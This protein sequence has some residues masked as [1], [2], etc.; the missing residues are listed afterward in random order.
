MTFNE[1]SN[2]LFAVIVGVG[3]FMFFL[4]IVNKTVNKHYESYDTIYEYNI[5]I[6]ELPTKG[7][8]KYILNR[9]YKESIKELEK[10]GK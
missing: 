7:Y 10:Q 5:T 2:M 6:K 4:I 8:A 9:K 1:L 3:I